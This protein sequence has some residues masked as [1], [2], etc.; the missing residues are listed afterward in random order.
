M[1]ESLS[2][3]EQKKRLE[4]YVEDSIKDSPISPTRK[5][6]LESNDNEQIEPLSK[7]E[8]Y[9]NLEEYYEKNI[10]KSSVEVK[11]I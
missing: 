1:T 10:K 5:E 8:D 6:W 9:L 7:E 3:E 2:Y 4:K 11:D